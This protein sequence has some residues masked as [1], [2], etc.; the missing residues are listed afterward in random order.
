MVVQ[1]LLDGFGERWMEGNECLEGGSGSDL[2]VEGGNGLVG[3]LLNANAGSLA[4]D[5]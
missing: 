1:G 3:L 5:T 4:V 2:S